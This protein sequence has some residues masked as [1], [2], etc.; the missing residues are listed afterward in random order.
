[1]SWGWISARASGRLTGDLQLVA[2][3]Q[4]AAG[5]VGGLGQQVAGQQT[6]QQAGTGAGVEGQQVTWL[7]NQYLSLSDR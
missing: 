7:V 1:M 5:A 2:G 6:L 3:N 4:V